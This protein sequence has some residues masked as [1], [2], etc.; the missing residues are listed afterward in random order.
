M[1][2]STSLGGLGAGGLWP[3]GGWVSLV[4]GN[5]ILYQKTPHSGTK[6]PSICTFFHPP[7]PAPLSLPKQPP[8]LYHSL[9]KAPPNLYHSLPTP[10]PLA[11]PHSANYYVIY[12]GNTP[13]NH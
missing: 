1:V 5:L 13:G 6:N 9:P 11:R 10:P 4:S 7:P 3:V 2:Q 12:P 8:N